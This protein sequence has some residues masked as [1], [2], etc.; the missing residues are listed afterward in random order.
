VPTALAVAA[1]PGR[2][3][4]NAVGDLM[5][6]RD[7]ESMMEAKGAAYP[8][9]AVR[10]LLADADITIANM[11]GTFTDSGAQADKFYTFRTAPR[12]A[13]GLADA[14]I[15]VVSLA[16][17]HTMDFGA[18][19]LTDTIA[20]LDAAGV[21][22][23]GAGENDAAA[24]QPVVLTANGLRIAFL[25]YE[26]VSESTPATATT[27]GEAWADVAKIDA[28]VRAAKRDA[29]LVVVSLHAGVEYTDA[30]SEIQLAAAKAAVDAGATLVLGHH[31]HVFQ[32]W[33]RVGSAVIVYGLGNFVFD[34]DFDDLA[35]LG[36]RPF[37]TCVMR[38]ELTKD[39]VQSVTCRPVYIDPAENR[40]TPATG[41]VKAQIEA[42]VE[43]LNA[44]LR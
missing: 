25:S 42:R 39:G 2:V 32:G 10:D 36:P 43:K 29:D 21:K 20:A 8:F 13:K 16:N 31:A 3:T 18:A 9:A 17:N 12:L 38:F 24:R 28:D 26:G 15:D 44:A 14:G 19:G 34:L 41:D 37:E 5:L 40:P 30:P 33:R 27:P 22:H 6:D 1:T 4:L 35:T 23:S 7:I 11:E